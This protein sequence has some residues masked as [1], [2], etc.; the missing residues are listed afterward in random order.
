MIVVHEMEP[1]LYIKTLTYISKSHFRLRN[2]KQTAVFPLLA[3]K[4]SFNEAATF[5]TETLIGLLSDI[6]ILVALNISR[7]QHHH[8]S[9][10]SGMFR[11]P[12]HCC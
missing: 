9:N 3:Q 6:D 4:C 12:F 1:Q 8:I 5:F 10:N 7:E 2:K 11:L